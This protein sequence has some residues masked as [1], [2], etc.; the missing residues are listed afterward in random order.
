MYG[1]SAERYCIDDF[2]DFT[3]EPPKIG[4]IGHK[5]FEV[6]LLYFFITPR[7]EIILR[8]DQPDSLPHELDRI[9]EPDMFHG[10]VYRERTLQGDC[11]AFEIKTLSPETR[12]VPARRGMG[13]KYR[14]LMP[15]L[16]YEITTQETRKPR[17]DDDNIL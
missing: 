11:A 4:S 14:Y 9:F 12:C 8:G 10:L 13:F 16:C 5:G 15:F 1:S 7:N 3:K 6:K 2:V 17:T